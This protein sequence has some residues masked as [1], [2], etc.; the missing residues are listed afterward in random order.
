MIFLNKNTTRELLLD[1][2]IELFAKYDYS[3]VSNKMITD[4][5]GT[6]SAMISYYFKSKENFY[7]AVVCHSSDIIISKFEKFHPTNLDTASEEDLLEQISNGLNIY[8]E[9]FFSDGG[10][11]FSI[12]YHRNLIEAQNR[13]VLAEYNRPI[14]NVTLRYI[15]LF[16]AYYR[17][18]GRQ[19]INV[20]F[21]M[22]KIASLVYFMLL[23]DRTVEV[24][25]P[26]QMNA[27]ENLENMLLHSV[28]NGY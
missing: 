6:N 7:H 26:E 8:L 14:D 3:Q 28:I 21:I 24:L 19:D 15:Q 25:I 2:G 12:I 27:M 4:L 23:H 13:K 11:N 5:V 20:V 16:T 9:A 10:R 1:A 22:I 17:K 18:I